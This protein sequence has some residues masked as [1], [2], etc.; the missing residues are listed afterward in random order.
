M[1]YMI[2]N[3]PIRWP[4]KEKHGL[5]VSENAKDL[6]TKVSVDHIV[7]YFVSC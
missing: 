5:E 6:I 2:Q 7:T 1:N 3:A 4:I